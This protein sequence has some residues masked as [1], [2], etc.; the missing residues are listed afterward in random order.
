MSS[1]KRVDEATKLK[2]TGLLRRFID[3]DDRSVEWAGEAGVAFESVFGEQEPY[4]SFVLALASYRPGGGEYLYDEEQMLEKCERTL[5]ILWS[6]T[7][8]E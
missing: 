3:G 6:G 8:E 4:N 2:L 5:E 1:L 7:E